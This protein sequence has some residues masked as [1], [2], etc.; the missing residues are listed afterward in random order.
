MIPLSSKFYYQFFFF[1][2]CSLTEKFWLAYKDY[3]NELIEIFCNDEDNNV[4]IR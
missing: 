3:M 2:Y 4:I 1:Q